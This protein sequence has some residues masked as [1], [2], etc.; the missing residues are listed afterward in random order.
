MRV[1]LVQS[2][3]HWHD[4]QKNREHFAERLG[5]IADSDMIV[6]PEMF[7]TG[8]SM[9]S[10]NQAEASDGA[11]VDWL[12]TMAATKGSTICGSLMLQDETRYVNRFISV[13][14]TGSQTTYDKRHLF[15]MAGEHEHF[16]PGQN[17]VV[18]NT[19]GWRCLPQVCYDL[20]FPVFSRNQDDY[21]VLIYVA[22]WPAARREHWKALLRARAIENQAFVVGVNRIG[23]DGNNVN[24]AGDSAVFDFNGE[25]LLEL[26]DRHTSETVSL[27][28]TALKEYRERFPAW[29]D[30]DQFSL[31]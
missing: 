28:L 12:A 16:S 22:N 10:S 19:A 4:P 7:N 6:L 11:S 17:R 23:T 13:D 30:A 5:L 24:Y 20:R 8:F 15:R 1:T 31:S 25:P 21:D 9:D 29:R 2:H 27:D 3:I 26:G 14:S 18:Y